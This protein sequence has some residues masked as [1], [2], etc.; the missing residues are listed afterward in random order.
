MVRIRLREVI[1][2]GTAKGREKLGWDGIEAG[3]S[4]SS[5][6][7]KPIERWGHK[8]DGSRRGRPDYRSAQ[9]ED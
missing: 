8:V 7:G 6:K 1:S 9:P 2:Q 3:L 4:S 5:E